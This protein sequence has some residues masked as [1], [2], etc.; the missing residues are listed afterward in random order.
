MKKTMY[1]GE[2]NNE[3]KRFNINRGERWFQHILDGT[4]YSNVNKM[5]LSSKNKEI[6]KG[7]GTGREVLTSC[8]SLP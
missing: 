6:R 4:G 7:A 2:I 5:T 3:V 1:G 8:A